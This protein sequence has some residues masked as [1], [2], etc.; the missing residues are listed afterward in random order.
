M[1]LGWVQLGLMLSA[2]AGGLIPHH[3]FE[4]FFGPSPGGLMLTLGFATVVEVC[5]EGSAPLAYEMYR[6]TGALGNAFAFLMG[7]VVTDYTE[8]AAMWTVVG[9]RTVL[10]MLAVTLPLVILTGLILNM[11]SV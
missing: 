5:S 7:G 9:R 10:W 3:V 11:L 2:V 4:R 6:H 8:L 1:V